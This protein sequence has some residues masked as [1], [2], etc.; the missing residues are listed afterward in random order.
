MRSETRSS[1]LFSEA[2][3][4]SECSQ[5]GELFCGKTFV[6]RRNMEGIE[7]SIQASSRGTH[8]AAPR[9]K[10]PAVGRKRPRIEPENDQVVVVPEIDDELLDDGFNCSICL[11]TLSQPEVTKCGH[12]FCYGCIRQH[13]KHNSQC[14]LCKANLDQTELTP[15][16][17]VMDHLLSKRSKRISK[18][19]KHVVANS[20][21]R[22]YWL[23]T[24]NSL[25]D[26]NTILNLLEL[27]K[28]ALVSNAESV[29]KSLVTG[30][31]EDFQK[32]KEAEKE[33]VELELYLIK[34]DLERFK[35]TTNVGS[36]DVISMPSS[37]IGSGFNTQKLS[38]DQ[39]SL[40][41]KRVRI[42]SHFE[43]LSKL[44]LSSRSSHLCN[45]RLL[46]SAVPCANDSVTPYEGLDDFSKSLFQVTAYQGLKPL[47]TINYSGDLL[48][49]TN[50]ASSVEFDKNGEFFTVAGTSGKIRIFEYASVIGSAVEYHHSN[51]ELISKS[52]VSCV[53]WSSY[54]ATH[55]ASSDYEGCVN[56][57]DVGMARNIKSFSEHQKRV[58]SVDWC[59]QDPRMLAS[60]S[61][62]E[63]IRL[64]STNSDRSIAT[65]SAT[66][67]ICSVKFAPD[68]YTLACG[69]TDKCIYMYDIRQAQSPFGILKG[70]TKSVSHVKFLNKRELVSASTDNHLK[71]WDTTSKTL[72]RS[73]QGHRNEKN[74]VGLATDG[75]Y[76]A[77]GSEDNSLYVYSKVLANPL[78]SFK[79]DAHLGMFGR[80]I[81]ENTS[82]EF[83]SAVA[84]KKDSPIII[85]ANSQGSIKILQLV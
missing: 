9:K 38:N 64:W 19:N 83:V 56:L 6:L 40:A 77:C 75:N 37:S 10:N 41:D 71:I 85:G 36:V 59:P 62:D 61:D 78:F 25:S 68:S 53:A 35:S 31:L 60:G 5:A 45:T 82:T 24:I 51:T 54:Y 65:I 49:T 58:W 76:I 8:G 21:F 3:V 26:L 69:G 81:P 39:T 46:E 79:F 30:F 43:E 33:A 34:L 7:R 12:T 17:A 20:D 66:G 1:T 11:D 4:I 48:S 55:M 15:N 72:I 63:K 52:K 16:F 47:A 29:T 67:N 44:Y 28:E 73:F 2:V 18:T 74:F 22:D 14:P 23:S 84:W 42:S 32:I 50:I 57:W 13:I 70:H 80:P 27:R